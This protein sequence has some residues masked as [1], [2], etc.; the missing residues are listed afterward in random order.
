MSLE[1]PDPSTPVVAETTAEDIEA[2]LGDLA[3]GRDDH[4]NAP[5]FV[6]RP[7]E[8][9]EAL[10]ALRDEAGFDHCACVTAEE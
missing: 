1:D 3:V 8:V 4:M 7:D 5:G 9:Q 2:L 6:V 10:F